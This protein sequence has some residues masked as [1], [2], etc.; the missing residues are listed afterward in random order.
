M[1]KNLDH[2]GRW[3]NRIV[4]FRVSPMKKQSCLMIWWHYPD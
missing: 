3:R 4:A 2:N 1:E